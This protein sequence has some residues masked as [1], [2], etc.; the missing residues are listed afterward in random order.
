LLLAGL[1]MV[2]LARAGLGLSP[3]AAL[4]AAVAYMATPR[5]V[6]HLG[7]GHLTMIQTAAWLPWVAAACWATVRDPARWTVALAVSLALMALAGH[8]QL[9]F[10][11]GLMAIALALWLL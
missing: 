8:P 11:G 3:T 4:V 10:Y 1:G 5:L 9:A 2:V 6:G 7:A